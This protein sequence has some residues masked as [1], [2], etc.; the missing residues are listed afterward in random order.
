MVLRE[1]VYRSHND[2]KMITIFPNNS[3]KRCGDEIWMENRLSLLFEPLVSACFSIAVAAQVNVS[4]IK[5]RDQA[6][7]SR[8]VMFF[9]LGDVR[10]TVSR[11]LRM[12]AYIRQ[13]KPIFQVVSKSN[14]CYVFT[15]GHVGLLV[16][17]CCWLLQKPYAL[18]LR[19]D[20]KSGTPRIFYTLLRRVLAKADFV[21][22]TG[23]GLRDSVALIN[24]NAEAVVPMSPVL[25]AP[26]YKLDRTTR[27]DRLTL[28]FVGQI[29]IEKGILVLLSAF[30]RL[31]LEKASELELVYVGGGSDMP[32]LIKA[33]TEKGMQEKIRCVGVEKDPTALAEIYKN[34]HIFCLPSYHEGF[35]RVL[36]E[37]MHFSL[38]IV[39]TDVGQIST[40]IRDGHNGL[41]CAPA[42]VDS[43]TNKLRCLVLDPSLRLFL[44]KAGNKSLEPLLAQWQGKTHGSQILKWLD[45]IS[46]VKMGINM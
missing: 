23:N 43:L 46:F 1:A 8:A 12:V 38:P 17:M 40:V 28:L 30:E 9:P 24:P 26:L 2:T 44:G 16:V 19:G 41:L 6:Q 13:I 31:V 36:Y 42:S 45:R 14:L 5:Q 20:W 35:P 10:I 33:I 32:L 34:S 22:C 27:I 4:H 29:V 11:W 18:Y 15:P 7:I 25:F 39:T 37:A 21:I 3:V